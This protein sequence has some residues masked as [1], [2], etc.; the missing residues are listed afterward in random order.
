MRLAAWY[1]RMDGAECVYLT[2]QDCAELADLLR[3]LIEARAL[4]IEMEI[5]LSDDG[6]DNVLSARRAALLAVQP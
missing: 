1:A 3:N 6:H 2:G 4:L 5:P